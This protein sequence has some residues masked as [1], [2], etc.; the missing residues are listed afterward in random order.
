MRSRDRRRQRPTKAQR[1]SWW[2]DDGNKFGFGSLTAYAIWQCRQ[3]RSREEKTLKLAVSSYSGICWRCVD[4]SYSSSSANCLWL[5]VV[6][7]MKIVQKVCSLGLGNSILGHEIND[8]L[9]EQ[10]LWI[11]RLIIK[12]S[13]LNINNS[14]QL[15][16]DSSQFRRKRTLW[17]VQEGC[18]RALFWVEKLLYF[19]TTW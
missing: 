6:W 14:L 5:S 3:D 17:S 12:S 13:S 1:V 4:S 9:C 10:F 8:K 19:I 16:Q 18:W 2:H 7:F 11:R 15:L